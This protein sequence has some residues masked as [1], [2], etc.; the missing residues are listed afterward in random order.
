MCRASCPD[1]AL[2]DVIPVLNGSANAA[3]DLHKLLLKATLRGLFPAQG[4]KKI[5]NPP[6][7]MT[8]PC[9]NAYALCAGLTL[10]EFF[11]MCEASAEALRRERKQQR[12]PPPSGIYPLLYRSLQYGTSYEAVRKMLPPDWPPKEVDRLLQGIQQQMDIYPFVSNA[13]VQFEGALAPPLTHLRNVLLGLGAGADPT[14]PGETPAIATRAADKRP[15]E[16]GDAAPGTATAPPPLGG[17]GTRKLVLSFRRPAAEAFPTPTAPRGAAG[18]PR[19]AGE[20]SGPSKRP[21]TDGYTSRVSAPLVL[22]SA[23]CG[24]S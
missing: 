16:G 17:P 19:D 11:S 7:P 20:S 23:I 22:P 1:S 15:G 14:S 21:R 9:T 6:P 18:A 10:D 2:P 5:F 8:L 24:L 4:R 12:R 3:V 13:P